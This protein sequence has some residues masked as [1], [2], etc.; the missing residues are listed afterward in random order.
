MGTPD[1][2]LVPDGPE[3]LCGASTADGSPCERPTSGG[4]CWQHAD[5]TDELPE[6]PDH[7]GDDGRDCW[8]HHVRECRE[9]GVLGKVDLTVLEKACEVYEFGREAHRAVKKYGMLVPGRSNSMKKNPAS[10][11]HLDYSKEYRQYAKE[12]ARLKAAAS[13]M[14]GDDGGIGDFL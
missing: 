1:L 6:P 9:L 13:P 8:Y 11:K 3:G 5:D 14:G 12:I 7:L 10:G 2:K 4:R